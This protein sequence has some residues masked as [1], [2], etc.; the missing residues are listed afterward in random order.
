MRNIATLQDAK[1]QKKNKKK[2]GEGGCLR[3]HWHRGGGGI[4]ATHCS[5]R[6]IRC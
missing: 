5:A 1:I 4:L 2:S 3:L 6:L